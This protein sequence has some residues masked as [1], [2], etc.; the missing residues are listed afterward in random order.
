MIG[1]NIRI[2]SFVYY[3]IK[4]MVSKLLICGRRR[5]IYRHFSKQ[6]NYEGFHEFL[7]SFLEKKEELA[8]LMWS[9]D[10][11]IIMKAPP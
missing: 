10:L 8:H 4:T 5:A 1:L 7:W 2:Y 11:F 9:I 3:S 6:Y